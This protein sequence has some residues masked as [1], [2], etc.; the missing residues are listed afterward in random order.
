MKLLTTAAVL[1]ALGPD[2][3][4]QTRLY[5]DGEIQNGT[6]LGGLVVRGAGDPTF[7][8]RYSDGDLT[9]TFRQ[10]AD[11]LRALGVR[12][13]QGPV[14][15]DDDVFDNL[16]L[17]Q[18]WQWDDLVW[19]Y[20]A[21]ISG[22]QFSEGT[23]HVEVRGTTAG[24]AARIDAEPDFG[25][26]RFV[27][28]STTTAGGSIR[29]GYSRALSDNVFTVTASVP[30]G[31]TE[32]EDLAVVNPTDYFISTMVGVF[33]QQGIEV[34][35]D[36]VDVDEWGRSPRYEDLRRVATHTSP[37][38]A[39]IVAQTNTDSNNLYAEHLLRTLG[40]YVYQGADL[41]TGS[42]F[43]G[44]AA[45]EPFLARLDVDPESFRVAD[46]SGLSALKPADAGGHRGAL[47]RDARPPGPRHRSRLRRVA[48]RR[49]ADGHAQGPL[50]L[51]RREGQRPRQDGL[52]L[53]RAD[54]LGLRHVG[55][56]PHDRV[57]AAVQQLHGLDEPRE[58]GP[59]PDRGAA[60]GL[61][62]PVDL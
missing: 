54:A 23:V 33:R 53:G 40:T 48:A 56:R 58:P 8:G 59:G 49:R 41:P 44:Y 7:G 15:G 27:N 20:G 57:L 35:G 25:Y 50:P 28:R 10:W 4:Y 34:D 37:S 26:V 13:V 32:T 2:F 47:A 39:E 5:A 9:R 18:G 1:D 31:R 36:L 43:A 29:E 19:Y 61:R 3:R 55:Q 42:A 16:P 6:L 38:L 60:G 45:M 46:G 21:E 11:S 51:G 12:R 24:S 14:I 22:L 30:E 62:G 17:G 52:H